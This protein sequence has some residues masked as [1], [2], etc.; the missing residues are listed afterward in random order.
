MT[1]YLGRKRNT[2]E[3]RGGYGRTKWI[4]I[5]KKEARELFQLEGEGGRKVKIE[6]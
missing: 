5:P 3:K 4:K 2:R 1:I 6:K